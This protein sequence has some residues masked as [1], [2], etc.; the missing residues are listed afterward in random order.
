MLPADLCGRDPDMIAVSAADAGGWLA[1]FDNAAALAIFFDNQPEQHGAPVGNDA[2]G[3]RRCL[4]QDSRRSD[5]S[6]AGD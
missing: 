6:K 1:R 4:V 3:N 5:W 2:V